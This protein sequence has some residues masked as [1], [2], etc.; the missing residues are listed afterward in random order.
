MS[1]LSAFERVGGLERY[2][3]LHFANSNSNMQH[4]EIVD[5]LV[6]HKKMAIHVQYFTDNLV[7]VET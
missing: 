7:N 4:L 6:T 2:R 5:H 3:S 1:S